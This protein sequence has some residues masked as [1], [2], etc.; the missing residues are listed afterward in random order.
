MKYP[1]PSSLASL[2]YQPHPL[3]HINAVI[4]VCST[5]KQDSRPVDT[6]QRRF[7]DDLHVSL[8]FLFDQSKRKQE[9]Y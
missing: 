3:R 8:L 9:N 2:R 6:W 4:P 7:Y 1:I 5:E